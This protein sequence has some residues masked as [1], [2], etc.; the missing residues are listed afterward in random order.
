ML[1]RVFITVYGDETVLP[2]PAIADEMI[3]DHWE[4]SSLLKLHH[5]LTQ[6]MRLELD[7]ETLG[8]SASG[9]VMASRN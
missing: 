2:T 5:M 6:A 9:P 8:A 7:T 4:A 3:A 1:E